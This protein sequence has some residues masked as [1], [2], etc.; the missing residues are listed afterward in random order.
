M[1]AR[2][3]GRLAPH[4]GN[5]RQGLVYIK[6]GVERLVRTVQCKQQVPLNARAYS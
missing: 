1:T 4:L 5:G 3:P 6:P 2:F